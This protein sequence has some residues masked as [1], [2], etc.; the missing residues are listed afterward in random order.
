[1]ARTEKITKDDGTVIEIGTVIRHKKKGFVGSITSIRL[2]DSGSGAV[3][4][5]I[6]PHDL[7]ECA[8]NSVTWPTK[9]GGMYV[10]PRDLGL[11][12]SHWELVDE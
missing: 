11:P 2:P 3:W 5:T 10:Q 6:D 4:V 7:E 8:A 1:M 12:L 9:G